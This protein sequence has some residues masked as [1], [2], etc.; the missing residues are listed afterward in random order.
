[1]SL[2]S[3]NNKMISNPY[4]FRGAPMVTAFVRLASKSGGHEAGGNGIPLAEKNVNTLCGQCPDLRSL[5]LL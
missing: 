1:M 4:L 2:K 5:E 3:V